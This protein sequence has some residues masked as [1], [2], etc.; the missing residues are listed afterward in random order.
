MLGQRGLQLSQRQ[1]RGRLHQSK[2]RI[3]A[4]L[5]PRRAPVATL[6]LRLGVALLALPFMPADGTR[7]AHPKTLRRLTARCSNPDRVQHAAP[8]INR[9][10][11]RHACRPPDPADSLDRITAASGIP[12]D[13]FRWETALAS[14]QRHLPG[15]FQVIDRAVQDRPAYLAGDGRPFRAV[16]A[17]YPRID[18][19][20]LHVTAEA[21]VRKHL[22][23]QRRGSWPVDWEGKVE[24]SIMHDQCQQ[25]RVII[26]DE[27]AP[28]DHPDAP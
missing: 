18:H 28:S 21:A 5:D 26:A 2:D 14:L 22:H 15:A 19:A 13:S 16:I 8:Q 23:M 10:R 1:V 24:L 25:V 11:F 12:P 27:T 9:Q 4:R 6:L 17:A 7:G 20:I 3:G